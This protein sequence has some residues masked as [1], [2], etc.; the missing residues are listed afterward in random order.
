MKSSDLLVIKTLRLND[1]KHLL[2]KYLHNNFIRKKIGNVSSLIWI[3]I[4]FLIIAATKLQLTFVTVKVL[5]SD[6]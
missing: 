6:F 1:H 3:N 2:F 4:D 5:I